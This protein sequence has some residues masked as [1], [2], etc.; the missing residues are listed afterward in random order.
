MPF[1]PFHLGPAFFLGELFEKKVSIIS[2]L[3]GSIII[4]VRAIYCLFTGCRPLHGPLHT[5]MIATAIAFMLSFLLYSQRQRLQAVT[6]MLRIEQNYSFM[7]IITGALLGTW[8]HV[9]LDSFLYIDI[10]PL[11]PLQTNPFLGITESGTL[12]MICL[13]SFLLATVIYL[14]RYFKREGYIPPSRD[15]Q[16]PEIS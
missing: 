5:F 16:E 2:I 14:H 6:R 8:N 3:L 9:L 4:D 11:W 7:S 15:L 12:Y 1:T 13:L 10:L